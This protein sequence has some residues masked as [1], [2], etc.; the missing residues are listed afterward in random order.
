[1]S[2]TVFTA[3]LLFLKNSQLIDVEHLFMCLNRHTYTLYI[4]QIASGK[5]LYSIG[6]STWCCMMTYRGGMEGRED[7]EG[8][9]I[10]IMITDSLPC[11]TEISTAL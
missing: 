1:M 10:C 8:K 9:D 11:T 4:K 6:S 3:S 5:L 7:Q 2:P